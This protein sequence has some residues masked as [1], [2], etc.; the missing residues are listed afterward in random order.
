LGE[1]IHETLSSK[2]L[3]SKEEGPE[4]KEDAEDN[5]TETGTQS[6]AHA[7]LLRKWGWVPKE[8]QTVEESVVEDIEFMIKEGQI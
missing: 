6:R 5:E 1:I 3:V 4:I 8:K 2:G 7:D